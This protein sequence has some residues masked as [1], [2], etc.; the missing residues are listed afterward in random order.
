LF[1]LYGPLDSPKTMLMETV[2]PTQWIWY[3]RMPS[4]IQ[5]AAMSLGMDTWCI[6]HVCLSSDSWQS[7]D[8]ISYKTQYLHFKQPHN[9][10]FQWRLSI[11]L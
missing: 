4:P 2:D 6:Q 8:T 3:I 10:V 1:D 7:N 5:E 9:N 11:G